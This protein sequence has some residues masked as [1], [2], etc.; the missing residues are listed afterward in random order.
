MRAHRREIRFGWQLQDA[1]NRLSEV[2]RRAVAVGP[3]TITLHGKPAAVVVS[4][5]EF[6]KTQEPRTPLVRFLAA[7]PLKGVPL[8]LRREEDEGRDVSL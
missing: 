8:D 1:K 3:Q 7:S 4:Y 2:V 6:K 5:E